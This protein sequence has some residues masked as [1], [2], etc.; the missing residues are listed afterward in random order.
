MLHKNADN[1]HG[2]DNAMDAAFDI[3]QNLDRQER[4]DAEGFDVFY[5]GE[6][7]FKIWVQVLFYYLEEWTQHD[8]KIAKIREERE[9][10]REEYEQKIIAEKEKVE[11]ARKRYYDA[12][13]AQ[14]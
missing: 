4:I 9:A 8:Q 12:I 3:I 7:D 5:Y 14:G 1:L 10:R 2:H 11:E 6:G 13:K